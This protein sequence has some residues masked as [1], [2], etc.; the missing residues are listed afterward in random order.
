[1]AMVIPVEVVA[2]M[3]RSDVVSAVFAGGWP[4]VTYYI[5]SASR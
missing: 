2:R 4:H 1:M 5:F 3:P